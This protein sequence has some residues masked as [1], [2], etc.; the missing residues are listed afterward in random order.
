MHRLWKPAAVAIAFATLV[1][2]PSARAQ[3]GPVASACKDEIAKFCADKQHGQG[4][5]RACLEGHKDQ[6]SAAC[7]TA[8]D[9]TGPGKRMM[10]QP[11]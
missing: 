6:A 11:Q 7:K 4:Q 8:L 10:Q 3:K 9:T 2:P 5:I 1:L